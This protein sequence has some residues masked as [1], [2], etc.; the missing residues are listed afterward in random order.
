MLSVVGSA[1]TVGPFGRSTT[2][3]QSLHPARVDQIYL[4]E[5]RLR[6]TSGVS[7]VVEDSTLLAHKLHTTST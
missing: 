5:D 3:L 7:K 4:C 1:C 6:R 2:D